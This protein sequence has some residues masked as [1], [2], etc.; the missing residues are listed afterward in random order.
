MLRGMDRS[1]LNCIHF[2][3][4]GAFRGWYRFSLGTKSNCI[5]LMASSFSFIS[6]SFFSFCA[7]RGATSA[8]RN[9]SPKY[10]AMCLVD[11]IMIAL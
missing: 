7:D 11:G 2:L 6:S 10:V 4:I 3:S 5:I 9:N 1:S 8:A